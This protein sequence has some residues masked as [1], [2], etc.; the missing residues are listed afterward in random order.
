MDCEFTEEQKLFRE[1]MQDLRALHLLQ[2]VAGGSAAM[3]KFLALPS[4]ESM[5]V[6]PREAAWIRAARA[7]VNR[8]IEA[9]A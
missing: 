2:R 8:E 3:R 7:R 9:H 4:I 6:Y 1:A 5:H